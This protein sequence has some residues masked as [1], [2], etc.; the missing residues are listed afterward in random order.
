MP[1]RRTSQEQILDAACGL[2]RNHGLDAIS[3]RGVARACQ[4]S[5]GSVYNYYPSRDELVAATAEALFRDAFFAD[6]CQARSQE[7]YLDYCRRLFAGLDERL[8]PLGSNWLAQ[9]HA[10]GPGGREAGRERM[11]AL[12]S[13]MLEGL[14]HVLESD[15]SVRR[16]VLRG[17]LE[18]ERICRL[19]LDAMFDALRRRSDCQ[20]LFALMERALYGGG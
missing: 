1:R 12:L 9:L 13:H 20:T 6:F 16:E 4:I 14:A 5:V 8:S 15:P 18:P 7:P 10:L 11:D 19:T 17:Q 2:A 3:I